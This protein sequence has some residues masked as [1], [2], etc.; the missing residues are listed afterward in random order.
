MKDRTMWGPSVSRHR[1]VQVNDQ[2]A[3]SSPKKKVNRISP[4]R[5]GKLAKAKMTRLVREID[6]VEAKLRA[7]T[8][9]LFE[10]DPTMK[11]FK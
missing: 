11:A 8:E 3:P 2:P 4:R 10:D 7:K 6:D 9:L 5:L 1:I